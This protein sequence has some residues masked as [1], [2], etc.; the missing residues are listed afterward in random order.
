VSGTLKALRASVKHPPPSGIQ[1]NSFGSKLRELYTW[2]VCGA[3]DHGFLGV[4]AARQ[5]SERRIGRPALELIDRCA[6]TGTR[7]AVIRPGRSIRGSTRREFLS[8]KPRHGTPTPS[9]PS[10]ATC[11]GSGPAVPV[12]PAAQPRPLSPRTSPDVRVSRGPP[13]YP[14]AVLRAPAPPAAMWCTGAPPRTAPPLRRVHE[15]WTCKFSRNGVYVL[16]RTVAIPLHLVS[17][18][19]EFPPPALLHLPPRDACR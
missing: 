4:P 7:A 1:T 8:S 13:A 6:F 18:E 3:A 17:H 10:T 16:I 12:L 15:F 14:Y 9:S 11:R 19:P 2:S 5:R